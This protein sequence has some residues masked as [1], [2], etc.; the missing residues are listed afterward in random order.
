MSPPRPLQPL[1][2]SL[3]RK[4]A[5]SL[6]FVLAT[7]TAPAAR[8]RSATQESCLTPESTRRDEERFQAL[9]AEYNQRVLEAD[10][11]GPIV[12]LPKEIERD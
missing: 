7:I 5:H 8:S 9:I 4:F 1:V 3:E 12:P 11:D 2:E 10:Q 6:R